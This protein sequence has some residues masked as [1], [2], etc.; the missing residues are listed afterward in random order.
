MKTL[1]TVLMVT[2]GAVLGMASLSAPASALS[3]QQLIVEPGFSKDNAADPLNGDFTSSLDAQAKVTFDFSWTQNGAGINDSGTVSAQVENIGFFD[4]DKGSAITAFGIALDETV[5]F[6]L[7]S[8]SFNLSGCQ[9]P[10]SSQNCAMTNISSTLFNQVD[11]PQFPGVFDV[12][13]GVLG[14]ATGGDPKKGIQALDGD[15]TNESAVFSW[16]LTG[17]FDGLSDGDDFVSI[18]D[19]TRIFPVENN[20]DIFF[21]TFWFARMQALANDDSDVVG[22]SLPD[23]NTNVPAPGPLAILGIGLLGLGLIG[24]RGRK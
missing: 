21:D 3:L 5:F 17:D 18:V 11:P 4:G 12:G 13:A 8:H 20:Q 14:R 16:T 9:G 22:G 19:P 1:R 2:G 15:T 24:R 10:A 7:T 6:S 23:Q